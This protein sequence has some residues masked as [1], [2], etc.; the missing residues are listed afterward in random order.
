[1]E[2]PGV[3]GVLC[4]DNQGLPIAVKGNANKN[5]SGPIASLIQEASAIYPDDDPNPIVTLEGET[6]NL[7]IKKQEKISMAIHKVKS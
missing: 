1:M 3:T 6:G 2:E 4:I 5:S 7:L